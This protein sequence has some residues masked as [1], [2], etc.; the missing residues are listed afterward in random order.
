MLRITDARTGEP[1]ELRRTLTRVHAH[2]TGADTSALRVLLVADV[3]ARALE[4]DGVPVLTVAD[5][6]PELQARATALGIRPAAGTTA[7]A[8]GRAALHVAAPGTAVPEDGVRITVAP[9][10]NTAA[11]TSADGPALRY[12]LL[13]HP[14]AETAALGGD[15]ADAARDTLA[16]WR[17][18][19]AAWATR[20]SRPVPEAVLRELRSAWEDDLDMPAVLDVLRRVERVDDLPDGAR[21]ETYAYADRLLGLELTRD[22]GAPA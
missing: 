16:R 18:A 13:A 20:P 10:G 19:V 15:V 8:A 5:P 11:G 12:A 1:T 14:R 17:G 2:V 4:L 3:L 9:A 22:V 21:F 7:P 6:P